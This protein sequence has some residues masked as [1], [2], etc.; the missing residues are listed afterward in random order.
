[1][2][3]RDRNYIIETKNLTKHYGSKKSVADLNIDV[4]KR[5]VSWFRLTTSPMHRDEAAPDITIRTVWTISL[6][7]ELYHRNGGPV[8]LNIPTTYC[9]T[10]NTKELP[11]QRIINRLYPC[12]L[13]T[14]RCV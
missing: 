8:H 11:S 2:C 7:L 4:Y 5:Q 12:L 10:F 3:I 13:Y 14:S 9:P 1:M 6:I